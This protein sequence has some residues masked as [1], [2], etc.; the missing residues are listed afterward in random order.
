MHLKEE[1]QAK[2]IKSILQAR[3]RKN[4]ILIEKTTSLKL[5]LVKQQKNIVKSIKIVGAVR[6]LPNEHEF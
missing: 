2:T 3:Q 1:N 4:L 5:H 6:N